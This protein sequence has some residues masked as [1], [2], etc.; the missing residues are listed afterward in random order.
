MGS[1]IIESRCK[2][3]THKEVD[4]INARLI[5]GVA[6]RKVAEEFGL[7][8]KGVQNHRQKHLPKIMVKAQELQDEEAADGMLAQVHSLYDKALSLVEKA[9]RDGKWAASTGAI[10]EARSCLELTSKLVGLLK[11]GTTVNITYNQQFIETR[12]RI[13]EALRPYP[14]AREAVVIALGE[15]DIIDAEYEAVDYPSS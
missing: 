2:T 13:V 6:V 11:S 8:E 1:S 7:N 9:E 15:G 4:V 5:A 14:E 10:K 12:T 3:C